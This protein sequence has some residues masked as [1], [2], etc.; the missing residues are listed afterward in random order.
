MPVSMPASLNP[1][2][3]TTT[4][5]RPR[6]TVF[7][8]FNGFAQQVV[9]PVSHLS[10]E[11]NLPSLTKEETRDW[12]RFFAELDAP[13]N[14]GTFWCPQWTPDYD[15]DGTGGVAWANAD[16]QNLIDRKIR[17]PLTAAS[18]MQ[19]QIG[20]YVQVRL[21]T[22]SDVS[23]VFTLTAYETS[24]SNAVYTFGETL[25]FAAGTLLSVNTGRKVYARA[26]LTDPASQTL[27]MDTVDGA[28]PGPIPWAEAMGAL[29]H[30]MRNP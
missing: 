15:H 28:V 12:Q 1:N 9:G 27:V 24:G 8:D 13:G 22:D 6:S 29:L 20:R 2:A 14:D 19:S 3:V 30:E 7:S 4:R 17:T 16:I 18:N 23:F 21:R 11:I 5:N 10:G 25:P 26:L